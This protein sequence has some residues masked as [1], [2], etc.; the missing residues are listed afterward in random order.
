MSNRPW[1]YAA[2]GTQQGPISEAEL[3]DLVASGAVTAETLVWSEGMAGWDKAGRIPGL[4]PPGLEDG[5]RAPGP[6]PSP[7]R[8]VAGPIGMA[9]LS[10]KFELWSYLG[11]ALLFVVGQIV[12]VLTPWTAV[13]LYRYVVDRIRVPGRPNLSFTGQPLDIWYVF[14]GMAILGYV[15]LSDNAFVRLIALVSQAFLGWMVL[16]WGISKL[17]SNGQPLPITFEGSPVIYFGWYVFML[18]SAVTIIG[19]AWVLTAWMRWI[20]RNIAGTRREV[21][22]TASGLQV[23]WRTLLFALGCSLI[24]P[25]PWAL[26]W[27]SQWYISQ[28]A[29]VARTA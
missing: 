6:P 2:Q 10:A 13:Y 15:G 11:W 16:S 1:Y 27:Y 4:M 18:V 19:W 22:F 28:F 8:D 23:L 29:L 5:S 21:V 20:C 9:P 14:V 7:S 25:I 3:G 26:R 12:V 24:L 17:A